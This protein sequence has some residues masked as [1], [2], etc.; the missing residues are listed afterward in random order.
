MVDFDAIFGMDWLAQHE[1]II[2]CKRRTVSLKIQNEKPFVFHAT[3]KKNTPG[4]LAIL[5][6][7]QEA[8]R[9]KLEEVEVVKDFPEVF[10]D[11][12]EGLT[13][14]S[15]FEIGIELLPGTKPASKAP[16]RLAPTEMKEL[17]DQLQELLDKGELKQVIVKNIYPLPR[18]D[19]LFDQFQGAVV[20]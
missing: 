4:F 9:P 20:F 13:P 17:K 5:T 2:D 16:Y 15:E 7:D 10:P 3:S 12:V 1:A 19:D 14:V 18:I 8:Q 6:G 11:D